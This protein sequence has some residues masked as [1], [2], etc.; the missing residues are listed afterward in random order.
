MQSTCVVQS[1]EYD[2]QLLLSIEKIEENIKLFYRDNQDNIISSSTNYFICNDSITL[3]EHLQ[4]NSNQI[5][6]I[7]IDSIAHHAEKSDFYSPGSLE[8]CTHLT[9]VLIRHYAEL[10]LAN[11]LN[12]DNINLIENQKDEIL[13]A[14]IS[15][16]TMSSWKD[17][18]KT[19]SPIFTDNTLYHAAVEAI[20][21]AGLSGKIFIDA[22]DNKHYVIE[23]EDGCNFNV[24]IFPKFLEKSNNWDK[25]FVKVV[26]VDG[27]IEKV[28][29][30]HHILEH[31]S[32][33]KEPIVIFARGFGEE[34]L[35]TLYLNFLR[36]TL[37]VFPV[38]V[39][40]DENVN[41]LNDIAVVC[42]SDVVSSIKGELI[43]SID[44][45]N[46]ST[47]EKISVSGSTITIINS[48]ANQNI[49]T[50]I[51][52]ILN[53]AGNFKN[54]KIIADRIKGL[55]S[56]CVTIYLHGNY[57]KQQSDYYELDRA[58]RSIKSVIQFGTVDIT[59]MKRE[60]KKIDS[61]LSLMILKSI[62]TVFKNKKKITSD[63][64]MRTIQTSLSLSSH[65]SA[66]S[67]MIITD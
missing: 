21:Q 33:N 27:I 41:M 63:V 31:G 44:L 39:G 5:S 13:Q 36:K 48:S 56:R 66:A 43:S 35:S 37:D 50:H 10:K 16:T 58:L 55:T 15:N 45:D 60:L 64:L 9:T 11:Q 14:V 46:L 18:Q 12:Q 17:L 19:L 26:I 1:P 62:N 40:F 61:I 30:I 22:S 24:E 34:V 42:D 59:K 7:L 53:N 29:E 6:K 67:T 25:K 54:S 57:Q 49:N 2:H 28:S 32:K 23:I 8:I 47:V 4:R 51:E 3:L 38:T 20:K 65:L 52:N